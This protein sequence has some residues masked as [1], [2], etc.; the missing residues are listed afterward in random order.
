VVRRAHRHGFKA[1]AMNDA[2]N[3]LPSH[4]E[5]IAIFDA[6]FMPQP[7]F[8]KATIPYMCGMQSRLDVAGVN[9][10]H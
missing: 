3:L 9:H 6:D 1:G 4:V 7:D 2:M 5:Y 10:H 8:L